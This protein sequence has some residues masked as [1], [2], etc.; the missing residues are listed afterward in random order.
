MTRGLTLAVLLLGLLS[1]REF[2][3]FNFLW[4]NPPHSVTEARRGF[5]A[6]GGA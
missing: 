3:E 1:M 6:A 2:R 4:K 5:P